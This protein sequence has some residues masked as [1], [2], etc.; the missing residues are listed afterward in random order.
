MTLQDCY[1][2]SKTDL[3]SSRF[4]LPFRTSGGVF[5]NDAK[6]NPDFYTWNAVHLNYCDGAS[7]TG[8]A[9]AP[10][11][12]SGQNVR[13]LVSRSAHTCSCISADAVAWMLSYSLSMLLGL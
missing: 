5:S 2:R 11:N 12:V 8:N 9:D 13:R 3:G 6:L 4:Y 10:V 7:W 1:N